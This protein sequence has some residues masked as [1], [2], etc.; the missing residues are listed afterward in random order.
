MASTAPVTA[1]AILKLLYLIHESEVAI[2]ALEKEMQ[3]NLS[4]GGGNDAL[5]ATLIGSFNISTSYSAVQESLLELIL[6][7]K[8]KSHTALDLSAASTRFAV[9]WKYY[10]QLLGSKYKTCAHYYKTSY[11]TSRCT[12]LDFP[13]G[14]YGP[15][16]TCCDKMRR[17]FELI[18]GRLLRARLAFAVDPMDPLRSPKRKRSAARAARSYSSKMQV[19]PTSLYT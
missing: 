1:A 8:S 7:L 2:T 16:N 4:N 10:H 11:L 5:Q 14:F 13:Y 3:E 17:L 9:E 15:I 18:E 19:A 6:I 12:Y